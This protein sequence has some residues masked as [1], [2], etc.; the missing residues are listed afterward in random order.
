MRGRPKGGSRRSNACLGERLPV[1]RFVPGFSAPALAAWITDTS[2][3]DSC[4]FTSADD[5]NY[6]KMIIQAKDL[7]WLNAGMG[8]E[9]HR[10]YKC[11]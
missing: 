2:Y 8:T 1:K 9:L 7:H 10:V 5:F 3:Y 4:D 6:L 11:K